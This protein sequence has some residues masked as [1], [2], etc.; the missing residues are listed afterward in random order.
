MRIP[1]TTMDNWSFWRRAVYI[2]LRSLITSFIST[3]FHF[4]VHNKNIMKKFPEGTPVIYCINHRSHLDGFIGASAV[5][6]PN[7]S[8]TRIALIGA[9]NLMQEN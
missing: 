6:V 3:Y 7:G 5:V 4:E 2:F 1:E 8:R 9:G